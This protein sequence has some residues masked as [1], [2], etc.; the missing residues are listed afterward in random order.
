MRLFPVCIF[1]LG[2]SLFVVRAAAATPQLVPWALRNSVDT[3]GDGTADLVDNAPGIS[4][5]PADSDAD[6]IGGII[7]PTPFTSVPNLGDPG[8]RML[9]PDTISS[10][11]GVGV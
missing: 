4:N 2:A 7:Y 1:V 3:G 10:G 6:Q 9:V 11:A 5:N 8:L